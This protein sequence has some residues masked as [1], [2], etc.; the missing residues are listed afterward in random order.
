MLILNKDDILKSV[1]FDE[2]LKAVEEAFIIQ[3]KG[4][5]LMPD[6]LHIDYNENVLLLMPAFTGDYFSTKLV[7]VFPE[8]RKKNLP[9]I[10]GSVLLND[11]TTG[12]TLAL[13][14]ASKL[15]ALRTGAV[16]ALGIVHT[17]PVDVSSVG[18]I[19]AG[20]QGFHQVLFAC[21]VRNIKS[22]TLF[23][24]FNSN[25][26][27]FV[28]SLK[29]YLPEIDFKIAKNS[30]EVVKN[31]EVIITATTSEAPVIPDD[32][33]LLKG[34]HFIGI[35]SY[36]PSMREFP[37][38]LFRLLD[39]AIIDTPFAMTESGDISVPIEKGLIKKEDIYTLGSLINKKVKINENVT[40][41]F[42]SVGMALFD[43]VTARLIYRK[44]LEKNIGTSVE[45]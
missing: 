37:D 23:D 6:R 9:V 4:N 32:K 21:A 15:T 14:E 41:L 43:L 17:T 8:N 13:L 12:E 40:T 7:S 45:F 2:L 39:N 20:E 19:G 34:K 10:F 44:A 18:L 30:E 3:E 38:N 33:D 29:K 1:T 31:S 11:G 35:G 28:D 5:F 42:K 16:G 27:D 22:V 26:N 25:L 24:A 36:K